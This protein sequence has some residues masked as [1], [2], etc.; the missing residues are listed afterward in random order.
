MGVYYADN[1]GSLQ[2]LA[3]VSAKMD[4]FGWDGGWRIN[5]NAQQTLWLANNGSGT[6]L[7]E[8]TPFVFVVNTV[9][10]E[11]VASETSGYMVDAL[12]VVQNID[13][14]Y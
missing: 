6:W 7:W 14:N 5:D 8:G 9:T 12:S 1:A 4:S 11:M 13:N 10:M 2:S 3:Q